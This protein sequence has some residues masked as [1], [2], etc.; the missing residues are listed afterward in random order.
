MRRTKQYQYTAE[1]ISF[2]TR[3]VD[4]VQAILKEKDSALDPRAY[5]DWVD[6]GPYYREFDQ[7]AKAV[8][9]VIDYN[10]FDLLARLLSFFLWKIGL[11]PDE[12]GGIKFPICVAHPYRP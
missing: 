9:G 10:R 11:G 3:V 8:L 1:E 4:R 2:S 12:A 6:G 7:R 5:Q